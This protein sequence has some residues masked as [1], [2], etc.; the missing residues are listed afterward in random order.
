MNRLDRVAAVRQGGRVE[1][2]HTIPH[3][4][5]YNNAAHQWGV[6]MLLW[7]LFPDDFERLVIFALT[8]DVG[9]AW[10]GDIPANAL[11]AFPMVKQAVQAQ[12]AG[13]LNRVHLPAMDAL[14]EDDREKISACDKLELYLWCVE[15]SLAGN[16]FAEDCAGTLCELFTTRPLPPQAH[17][18]WV[19]ICDN[20]RALLGRQ[21]GVIEEVQA[22]KYGAQT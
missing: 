17:A 22:R 18:L 20:P 11:W 1:R 3:S 14:S 6:A 7:E 5:S 15:Q 9:E 4:G 13:L 19:S 16:S 8:H 12:E 10:V 2:C 21:R